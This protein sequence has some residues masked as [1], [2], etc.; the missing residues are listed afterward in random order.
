MA[1]SAEITHAIQIK[2]KAYTL[3]IYRKE[4]REQNNRIHT[5]LYYSQFDYD[6]NKEMET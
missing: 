2:D 4:K 6:S 1:T 3:P 5:Q